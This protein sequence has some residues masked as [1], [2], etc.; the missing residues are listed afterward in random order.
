MEHR[1]SS[2]QR[3][4]RWFKAELIRLGYD[5]APRGGGQTQF[6]ADSGVGRATISR[7]LGGHGATDT[8]V[9]AQLAVALKVP[10]SVV[11][12]RAGIITETE[13]RAIQAPTPGD[14]RI[15]P[16]EAADDLGITDDQ[17][18]RLFINMTQTLQRHPRDEGDAAQR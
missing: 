7:I 11:L 15:T 3:F 9:L 1:D 18:R 14:R 17:S 2:E 5:L 8:K 16:D 4:A 13:L 10:L 6:A 12:V